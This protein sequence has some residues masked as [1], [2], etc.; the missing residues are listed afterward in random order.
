MKSKQFILLP[1]KLPH[2]FSIDEFGHNGLCTFCEGLIGDGDMYIELLHEVMDE[3][4]CEVYITKRIG[5]LPCSANYDTMV[6]QAE[7]FVQWESQ[8]DEAK[9]CFQKAGLNPSEMKDHPQMFKAL[10][11]SVEDP[12]NDNPS[13]SV[14]SP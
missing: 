9:T 12:D 6:E 5:C 11:I 8:V 4:S 3:R 7:L 1:P 2:V 13:S 10:R 14:P